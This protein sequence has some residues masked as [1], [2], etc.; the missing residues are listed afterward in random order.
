M[1]LV[2][3]LARAA[4]DARAHT[5]LL[6]KIHEPHVTNRMAIRE[7]LADVA[8]IRK[9][10]PLR[11][12]KEEPGEPVR[13]AAADE[14]QV[15]VLELVEELLGRQVLALQRADELEHVL[16]GDDI[17]GRRGEATEQVIDHGT[18]QILA[19]GREVDD[20][21]RRIRNDVRGLGATEPLAV[22]CLL[23]QRVERRRHEQIEVGDLR[24]LPKRLRRRES[25][26]PKDPA[27]AR[28][29]FLAPAPLRETP[30]DDVVQRIRLRQLRRIDAKLACQLFGDPFVEQAGA[31]IGLD[32]KELRPDD[33]D[34][35]A[36]FDEIEQVLP[37]IVV[38]RGQVSVQGQRTAHRATCDTGSPSRAAPATRPAAGG[39][40]EVS[41]IRKRGSN[42][43]KP[44]TGRSGITTPEL[45]VSSYRWRTGAEATR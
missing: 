33:G 38:E 9:P 39:C 29:S 13:E 3:E 31:A 26:L 14:Q 23:E 22:D 5:H 20:A 25:G 41:T 40:G 37:R 32:L 43:A 24:E 4:V 36:L 10:V 30:A 21:I 44:A 11:H 16:V 45:P 15:I 27:N 1:Q 34:D 35:S 8:R 18:G 6:Q 42:V 2:D 12:A 28:V 19:L 17:C 7:H